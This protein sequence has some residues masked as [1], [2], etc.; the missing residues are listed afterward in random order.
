MKRTAIGGWK[1]FGG[2]LFGFAS[3]GMGW[4]AVYYVSDWYPGNWFWWVA[5]GLSTLVVVQEATSYYMNLSQTA[6]KTWIDLLS[7]NLGI[8]LGAVAGYTWFLE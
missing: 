7:K 3:V 8:W 1:R 5:L 6:G 4:I 2:H